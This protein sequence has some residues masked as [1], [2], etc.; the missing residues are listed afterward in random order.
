MA[1]TTAALPVAFVSVYDAATHTGTHHTTIR[2]AIAAGELR[3][4]K[5]AVGPLTAK[6]QGVRVR[7]ADLDRWVESKAIPSARTP[8]STRRTS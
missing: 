4:Y 1:A 3:G 6:R 5:M 2:R 8:A 7:I